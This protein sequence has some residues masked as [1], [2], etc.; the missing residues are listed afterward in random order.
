MTRYIVAS[1]SFVN[2]FGYNLFPVA[3]GAVIESRPDIFKMFIPIGI[4][5]LILLFLFA[6]VLVRRRKPDEIQ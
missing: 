2:M 3:M 4:I 5:V 1:Y 6:E